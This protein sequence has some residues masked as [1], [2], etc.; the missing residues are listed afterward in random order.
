MIRQHTY[1]DCCGKDMTSFDADSDAVITGYTVETNKLSL[2]RS[3]RTDVGSRHASGFFPSGHFCNDACLAT[4]MNEMLTHANTT[5]VVTP[6][7]D[8]AHRLFKSLEAMCEEF[9]GHDLPYGSA[10]YTA[11]N[12]LL[13]EQREKHAS[14]K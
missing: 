1:C 3:E 5:L 6:Q 7:G 12:T 9:R 2:D 10:A 14:R 4:R 8:D 11:A 13:N